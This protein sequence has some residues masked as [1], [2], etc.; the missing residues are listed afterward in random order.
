M[1]DCPVRAEA[2]RLLH[3][4]LKREGRSFEQGKERLIISHSTQH[5]KCLLGKRGKRAELSTPCPPPVHPG[6]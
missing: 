6:R 5:L 1:I 3:S 2:P 4:H